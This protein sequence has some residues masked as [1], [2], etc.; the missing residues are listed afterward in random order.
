M[1]PIKDPQTWL[2]IGCRCQVIPNLSGR[3]LNSSQF[4]L[5][6]VPLLSAP[7]PISWA[8]TEA[9]QVRRSQDLSVAE[10]HLGRCS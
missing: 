1:N 3:I 7:G 8:K 5:G 10:V 4:R 9:V 6:S 2:A